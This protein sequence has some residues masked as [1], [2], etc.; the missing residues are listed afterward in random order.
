MTDALSLEQRVIAALRRIVRAIELHSRQLVERFGVTGPQLVTLQ[1]A[2]RLG[3]TPVSSLA[4]TV[5]VSHP[6]MTGILDRLEKRG[7][8][9]RAR[10]DNDRRRVSVMVTGRGHEILEATP[11]PLQ[12]RFRDEVAKLEEWEQSQMLATL[13]RIAMLMDAE[14]LEAAPVLATGTVGDSP[15]SDAE[16]ADTP[17]RHAVAVRDDTGRPRNGRGGTP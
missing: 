17:E 9:I 12:D 1:E 8:V 2:A 6:T 4:K 14:Q 13:Q 3:R 10:D 7:L 15:P 16:M 5:H 11:S